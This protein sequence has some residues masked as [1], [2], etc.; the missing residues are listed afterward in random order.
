VKIRNGFVSNSSSSN[1]IVVFDKKPKSQ[2]DLKK[3]LFPNQDVFPNP[4]PEFQDPKSWPTAQV[5]A[6]I[7]E[8]IKEQKPNNKEAIL[9]AI[10][11]GYYE[12]YPE[13]DLLKQGDF[14]EFEKAWKAGAE[15]LA[16]RFYLPNKFVYVFSFSDNDGEY[17]SALE[18]GDTFENVKHIRISC[19]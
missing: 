18:H 4:Y 17:W 3:K 15:K 6:T 12:G 10:S 1:F 8:M 16:K 2:D 11:Q 9:D 13:M 19:H 5:V 7:W 14:D